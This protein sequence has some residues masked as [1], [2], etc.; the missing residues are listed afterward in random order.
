MPLIVVTTLRLIST[1]YVF[2][3]L[4]EVSN[5]DV[6]GR[7][8]A[9]GGSGQEVQGIDLEVIMVSI[10]LGLPCPCIQHLEAP[11]TI[12]FLHFSFINMDPSHIYSQISAINKC[13]TNNFEVR[14]IFISHRY[15]SNYNNNSC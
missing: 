11:E 1:E 15:W 9:S 7:C 8:E 10:A 5:I 13:G 2:W 12:S 6:D 3:V 14:D 4:S